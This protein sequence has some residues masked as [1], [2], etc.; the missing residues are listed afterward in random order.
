MNLWVIA[1]AAV[2]TLTACQPSDVKVK[3]V[4]ERLEAGQVVEFTKPGYRRPDCPSRAPDWTDLLVSNEIR[5]R[6]V[7]KSQA[8]LP[9]LGKKPCY[10]VGS[11]VNIKVAGNSAGL[12]Q[13]RIVKLSLVKAESLRQNA[14]NDRFIGKAKVEEFARLK[15]DLQKA[16]KPEHE[17]LIHIVEYQYLNG[18]AADQ[19]AI[20]EKAQATDLYQET[21]ENG[22]RVGSCPA[23]KSWN[24]IVAPQEFHPLIL[25]GQI[26]SWYRLGD[27]ACLNQGQEVDVKA[28]SAAG[29]PSS[30]QV[31]ITKLKL[32]RVSDLDQS[33]FE[34]PGFDFEKLREK[35]LA[36]NLRARQEKITV[37]DVEPLTSGAGS[38]DCRPERL[39]AMTGSDP[40]AKRFTTVTSKNTCLKAGDLL[41]LMIPLEN[42]RSIEVPVKVVNVQRDP[43]ADFVTITVERISGGQE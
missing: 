20:E 24:D 3:T 16:L 32:F 9:G 31:R 23:D 1:V 2:L 27:S 43:N 26:K 10:R 42:E 34:L 13:V 21:S 18:S 33:R 17:G 30:G 25:G 37:M 39:N 35:I 40:R 12:G 38:N 5:Q 41:Y 4:R 6:I 36:D 15:E 7:L 29:T 8:T 22:Q 14:F 19:K 28:S 11:V